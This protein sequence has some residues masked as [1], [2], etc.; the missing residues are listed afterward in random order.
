VDEDEY[1]RLGENQ[2]PPDDAVLFAEL[3]AARER[4]QL[5]SRRLVDLQEEERRAVARELNDEAGQALTS[6]KIGLHLLERESDNASIRAQ[7]AELQRAAEGVQESLHRLASNLRPPAL[8]HL[9]V[10]AALRQL[11]EDL[12]ESSGILIQFEALGFEGARP[13]SRI[14]T[15]LFRIAQEAVADAIRHAGAS[16]ISVVLQQSTARLRLIVE[17]DGGGFDPVAAEKP[18]GLVVMRERVQS[19]GGT[20]LIECAPG[21][22]TTIIVDL[23]ES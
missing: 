7:A 8:D 6:I 21:S 13:S 4:L 16:H 14:E 12:S 1:E 10:V 17:D 3:C 9:G 22:G 19:L 5:L 18:L 23:P 20:L 15:E 11:V 2:A